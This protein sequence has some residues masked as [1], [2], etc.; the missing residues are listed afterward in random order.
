VNWPD[1]YIN[2]VICGDCLDV[3]RGIPDGVVQCC[4]TSPPYWGLRDYGVDGQHGL[5]STIDE[6]V[7]KMVEIFAEVRRVLRDDGTCWL[8][9]GDSYSGS[10]GAMSHDI[11]GKARRTGTNGRPPQS[12]GNGGL[13]PKDLCMIPS[14]VALALQGDGWYLR[15]DIIWSKPN[16]MPESVT[17]RPTTAHE[18]LFLLSKNERYYYDADAI[19]EPAQD[20]GSR[21]RTHWS[22]RVNAESYGQTPHGGCEDVNFA[23]RGRNKRTVWTIAT[24]PTHYAH[25]ATFP[26]KLVEPCILA[27][28]SEKGQCPECGKPWVR[29]TTKVET[30][31]TQKMADG[32]ATHEGGHGSFHRDGREA[33]EAGK[34]VTA[35]KTL[36]W[37]P[38]CLCGQVNP[39]P[40]IIL[41]PFVGSGTTG[42]R[43]RELGRNYVMIELNPD[44]CKIAEDRLAQEELF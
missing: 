17:D 20:W 12:F 31:Q 27:G 30:G 13:K 5:E 22:A 34:P 23:E 44:Y 33:G 36:G 3:M 29:V 40:Q 7:A 24:S 16:P 14:R 4:I 37:R 9:L 35:L 21:D 18:H 1:D 38:D 6:Y 25:F 32:W 42:K 11:E 8:N 43:A 28:T 41:D 26:E 19:R 10:W 15:S 39:V 2:R